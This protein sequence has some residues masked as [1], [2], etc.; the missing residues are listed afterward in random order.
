[1]ILNAIPGSEAFRSP[2]HPRL[3]H[4]RAGDRQ[5]IDKMALHARTLGITRLTVMYETLPIGEDGL[6]MAKEAVARVGQMT[7]TAVGAPRQKGAITAAAQ[8]I[9]ASGTQCVLVLG[10]P[11][12]AVE[13]IADLRKAGVSQS[14]FTFSYVSASLLAKVAGDDAARGVGITQAFPNPTGVNSPLQREFRA[15]MKESF[16]QLAPSAYTVYHLEGYVTARVLTAALR[17][18][19]QVSPEQLARTLKTMGEIDLGGYRV[20]FAKGNV[21]SSFVDIGVVTAGG[22]LLY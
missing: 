14:V 12:F 6:A 5:Q 3:F 15:A 10:S 17:R 21:G 1:V 11:A 2:G 16:P 20:N 22:R 18:T 9:A 19:P 13:S 4:L 7:M 8:K